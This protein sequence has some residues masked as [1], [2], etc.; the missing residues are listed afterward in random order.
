[1]KNIFVIE[2][3]EELRRYEAFVFDIQEQLDAYVQ[4]LQT[5]FAVSELPR[6]I[7]WT[8]CQI[9]TEQLSDIPIPAYTNEDRVVFTPDLESWRSIYLNQ[10]DSLDP[11]DG[12]VACVRHYYESNINRNHILQILGHEIAHHSD[13][14]VD[15]VYEKGIW[16]EEGMVEYIS[17]R[18]F[19]TDAE[20]EM[21]YAMNQNLVNLLDARYGSHSLEN[22]GV[23][24]YE[25]DYASIFFEYWRSALAVKKIID[26]VDG[27]VCKVFESYHR[28]CEDDCGQT[29]TQW[30][31]IE[32]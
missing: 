6:A 1:M 21:E 4:Y 13:W 12:A 20:F 25:G 19:L 8:S 15:D 17:R 26:R 29:L 24:T 10:L 28:W 9:A 14:F 32:Q 22:F 23:A 7:L 18:Y 5:N 30:F 11:E 2:N 3:E 31:G 16:F 27:D